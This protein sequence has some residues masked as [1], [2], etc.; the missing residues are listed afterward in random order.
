M[1]RAI[2]VEGGRSRQGAK[3][4]C[5]PGAPLWV[6]LS[7]EPDDLAW[8]GERFGFHPL[9]LEDCAH[10]DQLPKNEEYPGAI[11]CV[12]HRLGPTPDDSDIQS[13]ELHAFLTAEAVVTVHSAPIAELDRIF[14]RVE[15]EPALLG[16]GPDFLLHVVYD[17]ITSAH[18]AVADALSAEVDELA[19]EATSAALDGDLMERI[20]GLRGNHALLRRRLAPQRDV[21]AALARADEPLVQERNAPYF[22]DVLDHVLRITEQIDAGRDLLGS[23]M[24][25]HVAMQDN[26]LNALTTRL[27]VVATI[28]LPLNFLVGFFGMNLDIV[29]A[30]IAKAVVLVAVVA[31]PAAMLTLFRRRKLL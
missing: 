13:R 27:T 8:L 24:D 15:N 18:F 5:D 28:F 10:E 20:L 22:R 19:A 12:V 1:L 16:R 4:I 30:P 14:A 11:F 25:V 23:V 3:E 29:P 9:A 7:P 17:E 2:R 21:F 26:R 6:D 31:L